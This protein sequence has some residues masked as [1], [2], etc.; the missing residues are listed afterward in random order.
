MAKTLNVK[1]G[2]VVTSG[3]LPNLT[4]TVLVNLRTEYFHGCKTEIIVLYFS[5]F[6]TFTEYFI[7]FS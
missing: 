5:F 4:A 1:V 2:E 3:E 7:V 6:F